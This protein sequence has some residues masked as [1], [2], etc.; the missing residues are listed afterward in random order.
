M[1]TFIENDRHVLSSSTRF[2]A[3]QKDHFSAI[4]TLFRDFPILQGRMEIHL[5]YARAKHVFSKE[6][7]WVWAK[8][9]RRPVCY[10]IFL[11]NFPPCLW[12][13]DRQEGQIFNWLTTPD[14]T[15]EGATICL[16]NLLISE[17]SLQI[18]DIIIYRGKNLWSSLCFSERW[19]YLCELWNNMPTEQ[20]FLTFRPFLVNPLSLQEWKSSYD[21]SLSWIIQPDVCGQPRWFWHDVVTPQV[22]RIYKAPTMKRFP[23]IPSIAVAEARPYSTNLPDTYTLFSSDGTNLGVAAVSEIQLSQKLRTAGKTFQV[24]VCWEKEFNKFRITRIMPQNTP[25]APH[26]TFLQIQKN[27]ELKDKNQMTE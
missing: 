18:E 25:I 27:Q 6:T 16:A 7:A 14:F 15:A 22:H 19:R 23:G 1:S 13:P 21:S 17:S 2:Q 12:R 11:P 24:E 20:P 10:L 9:D 5:P 26:N 3:I 8:F 4:Q